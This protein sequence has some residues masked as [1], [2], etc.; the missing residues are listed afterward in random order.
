VLAVG[1]SL[2]LSWLLH[3]MLR[4]LPQKAKTHMI[5]TPKTELWSGSYSLLDAARIARAKPRSLK[6]WATGYD[7]SYSKQKFHSPGLLQ[8]AVP[9]V[10]GEKFLTFQ[11]LVEM[12]F[13]RFFHEHGVSLPVIRAVAKTMATRYKTSHPFAIQN[14][15]TDGTTI[16]ADGLHIDDTEGLSQSRITEDLRQGQIVIRDFAQ[17]YFRQI[18]YEAMEAARYWPR[19]QEAGIVIDPQRSFGSP[20]DDAT[21]VPTQVLYEM[22]RAG[23]ATEII[24]EWYQVEKKFVIAAV[25]FEISLRRAV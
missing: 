17:P 2:I 9:D 10:D 20:I 7:Y 16:F 24:A 3:Y 19:G 6:R 12:M 14:L 23:E 4:S 22:Y 21:G 11:Q 13:I 18:D 5:S 8:S 15:Q 1:A 25:E